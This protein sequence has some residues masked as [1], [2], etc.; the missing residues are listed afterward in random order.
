V[1]VAFDAPGRG[2]K[3]I[4]DSIAAGLDRA[5]KELGLCS[6]CIREL[7][8]GKVETDS[9]KAERLRL[10][11]QG[12]YNPVIASSFAYAG[13]VATVAKEFPKVRFAIIDDATGGANVINVLFSENE[14]SFLVGAAAAMKSKTGRLG[15]VG[16]CAAGD[17]VAYEAGFAAG[18]KVANP[19]VVVDARYL[20]AAP[21]CLGTADAQA[22]TKTADAVYAAGADVIF[23]GPGS[24]GAGVLA[25][26]KAK[27]KLMIGD[28]TDLYLTAPKDQQSAILTSMVNRTDV[29]VYRVVKSF[30]DGAPLTGVQTFGLSTDGVGYSTS[31]GQI[32]DIKAKLD[33]LKQ[34]IASGKT[35]VPDSPDSPD[36]PGAPSSD[37]GGDG[38]TVSVG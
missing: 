12:G 38:G 3:A 36:S 34:Q 1:G 6:G 30:V 7:T 17:M 9:A 14:G 24:F 20:T 21:G 37:S 25:S 22:G 26:A 28:G 15:F 23:A 13:A 4:N 18:A 11:A 27:G 35:T 32:D 2:D 16:Y 33:D 5:K 8:G 19:N 10:L 29:A 31:G